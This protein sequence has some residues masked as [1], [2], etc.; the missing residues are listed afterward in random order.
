MPCA[1]RRDGSDLKRM[2]AKIKSVRSLNL[3]G[4][5]ERAAIR[6]L[7]AEREALAARVARQ[8]SPGL[9]EA[10]QLLAQLPQIAATFER[11]LAATLTG[12]KATRDEMRLISGATRDL[13]KGGAIRIRPKNRT[14][15]GRE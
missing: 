9:R 11:R 2:E 1:S 5:A 14:M 6:E 3:G 4:A 8:Q 15:T 13:I 12:G 7:E 10:R